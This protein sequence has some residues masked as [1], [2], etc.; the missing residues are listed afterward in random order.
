[1]KTIFT[2]SSHC[3]TSMEDLQTHV[4]DGIHFFQFYTY[5]VP[6]KR[7]IA[8]EMMKKA[9]KDGFKASVITL[10]L[11]VLGNR[12]GNMRKPFQLPPHLR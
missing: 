10:D 5:G 11:P 12:Y 3:N 1:M 4:P 2:L 7:S 6:N 8:L 9:A